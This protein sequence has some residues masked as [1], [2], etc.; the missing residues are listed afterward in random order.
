MAPMKHC[1]AEE[2]QKLGAVLALIPSCFTH[3]VTCHDCLQ[4]RTKHY[5]THYMCDSLVLVDCPGIVFPRL[6]VSPAMQV[7]KGATFP[8]VLLP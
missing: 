7:G 6:N 2:A 5:Q 8:L 3:P 4:G 1:L